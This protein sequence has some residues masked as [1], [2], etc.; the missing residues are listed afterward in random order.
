MLKDIK[1]AIL[2]GACIAVGGT[3]FLS[4]CANDA[5]WLGAVLFAAGLFTICVYGFNLY[6]GKVGYIAYN[7]Q[8]WHDIRLVLITLLFNLISTYLLGILAAYTFPIIK[9]VVEKIYLAKLATPLPRV[10]V[11]AVFCGLLMFLAVDTWKKGKQVGC[12]LYIATFILSG[13]EHSIANSFYN[14]A[15]LGFSVF[16]PEFLLKDTLFTTVCILGNAVGG[17]TVPLMMRK[18][19]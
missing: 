5:K 4:C 8:D 14:G 10:F 17:M 3:A 2:S 1:K 12:F 7:F 15:A 13:F 6:T 16:E 18:W 19:N 9:P 11:A